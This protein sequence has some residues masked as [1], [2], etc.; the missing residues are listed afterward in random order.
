VE[1]VDEGV[2]TYLVNAERI[3]AEEFRI[4]RDGDVTRC[5]VRVRFEKRPIVGEVSY[6]ESNGRPLR[7]SMRG[8]RELDMD[9]ASLNGAVAEEGIFALDQLWLARYNRDSGGEQRIDLFY[10]SSGTRH[11]ARVRL[12]QRET[13]TYDRGPVEVDRFSVVVDETPARYYADGAGRIFEVEFPH[14]RGTA[15]AV[16]TWRGS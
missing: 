10:P 3:G 9:A 5:R 6:E 2:L 4:E 11:V 8:P 14:R 16:R 12:E 1:L 13:R 7:Y 15:R